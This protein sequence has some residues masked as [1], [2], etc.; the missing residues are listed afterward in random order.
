MGILDMFKKKDQEQPQ[1]Q[2]Q[3]T[4][5]MAAVNQTV[6]PA[7]TVVQPQPATSPQEVSVQPIAP[8]QPADQVI[9][10]IPV[11]PVNAAPAPIAP[12]AAPIQPDPAVGVNSSNMLQS[13]PFMEVPSVNETINQ[14]PVVENI[15]PTVDNIFNAA[16]ANL[17]VAPSM[18]PVSEPQP[19]APEQIQPVTP[20][21]VPQA[22]FVTPLPNPVEPIAPTVQEITPVPDAPIA[23]VIDPNL[24]MEQPVNPVVNEQV[25]NPVV[26]QNITPENFNPMADTMTQL[27]DEKNNAQ[28]IVPVVEDT[29]ALIDNPQPIATP[30]NSLNVDLNAVFEG[31]ENLTKEDTIT[32]IV[33][34]AV[35][36]EEKMVFKSF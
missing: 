19:V 11:Q 15:Q 31:G 12:Q 24:N 28:D 32:N 4:P 35:A 23:P 30:N 22:D 20:T 16:P 34:E 2:Q 6:E 33:T 36:E 1:V 17:N 10:P 3:V 27:N 9:N 5:E 25:T 8:I 26:E 14:V 18:A 7:T 13:N 21:P 29:A